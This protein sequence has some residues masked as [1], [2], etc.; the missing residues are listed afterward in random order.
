MSISRLIALAALLLVP[1]GGAAA[2]DIQHWRTAGGVRV[3][4]VEARAL[5][6]IDVSVEFRA[7]SAFDPPG[8]GGL[9]VLVGQLLRFGAGG[10]PEEAIAQRLADVGAEL[11]TRVD[12]DRASVAL[13]TLSGAA[14]RR[15]A[16][17]ALARVVQQPDFPVAAFERERARAV[18]VLRDEATRPNIIAQRHFLAGVYREHPYAR[19][20]AG[21][22]ASVHSLGRDDVLAFH[23]A[24]YTAAHA[25]VAIVGDLSRA[26][27]EAL[28]E[29]LTARLPA[30]SRE[31]MPLP[32]VTPLA[33][34]R[35]TRVPHVAQQAHVLIGAPGMSR[36]DPDF[37]ALL[38]ANHVFGGGG[39]G[40]RLMSEVREQRG[41]AYSVHSRWQPWLAGGA[42]EIGVQTRRDQAD[43]TVALIMQLLRR[44]VNE[45]P[46]PREL[47]A[48][49]RNLI[50]GWP[51]RIDTNRELHDFLA[52]IGFYDLP[53][54]HLRNWPRQIE[55]VTA[56]DVQRVL[57]RIDPERMVTVI[58]GGTEPALR[59]GQH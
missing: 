42:F 5:P 8:H 22:P 1:A 30:G 47:E 18:S 23:R 49:R 11:V 48:A 7:G 45:G 25:V 57:R 38:V 50:G 53:L 51:L 36:S 34:A 3:L 14:E 56:A 59:V 52:L 10:L 31:A 41:L 27:A 46:T 2:A 40:S 35:V 4:F 12:V 9:A 15:Q 32:S 28:A 19:R 13:R 16:F 26:E 58:V 24:R 44:Y 21:E 29:Q 6:I 43:S 54:D 55:R 20:P 17:D 33:E 39:F 37:F